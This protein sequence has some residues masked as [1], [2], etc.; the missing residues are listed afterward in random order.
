MNDKLKN[1][2]IRIKKAR[3]QKNLTQS[4]FADILNVS[5]SHISDI[6]TGKTNF[7]VD[8]LILISEVLQIS[9]DYLLRTDIPEVKA[10]HSREIEEILK[11]C[12]A[13]ET[14]MLIKMMSDVKKTIKKL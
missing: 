2:G 7:G 13:S 8:I 3:K 11:D 10:I 14:E 1:V 12:S 9:T 5:K 6:E 4:Q